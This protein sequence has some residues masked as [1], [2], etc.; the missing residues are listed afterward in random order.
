MEVILQQVIRSQIIPLF[1]SF[2]CYNKI[3]VKGEYV[4][5]TTFITDWG[6]VTYECMLY[7]L[8][9]ANTT[10]TIPIQITLDELISIH[11]YLD[12]LIIYVKGI[13]IT[14]GFQKLW[15]DPF[16]ISFVPDTKSYILKDLHERLFS[17]TTNGSHLK[18]YV[19][20]T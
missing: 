17:Y 8:P 15:L 14:L 3:K 18:H 16:K 9:D 19:G 20:P 5:K 12:D 4:Y 2:F 7:V 1:D 11:I 10:F 6:T 13:L